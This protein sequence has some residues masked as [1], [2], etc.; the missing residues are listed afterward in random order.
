M[1]SPYYAAR[2]AEALGYEE[3]CPGKNTTL[4]N[5]LDLLTPWSG[6]HGAIAIGM[7]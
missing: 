3:F 5:G 6:T 2:M 4:L 7:I 1:L